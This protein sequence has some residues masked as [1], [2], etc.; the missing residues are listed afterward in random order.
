MGPDPIR[1]KEQAQ[2]SERTVD[3]AL[4]HAK[5]RRQGVTNKSVEEERRQQDELPPRGE[6]KMD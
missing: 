3:E 2:G 1:D 6:P 4:E 5:R